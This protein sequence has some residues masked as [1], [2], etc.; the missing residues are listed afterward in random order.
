MTGDRAG[1]WVQITFT[2]GDYRSSAALREL[3]GPQ[4]DS[5]ISK[6]SAERC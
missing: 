6:P 4:Q 3:S 2:L 1:R 5:F